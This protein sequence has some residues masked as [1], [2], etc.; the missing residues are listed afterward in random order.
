MV[1][2]RSYLAQPRWP[3]EFYAPS[4]KGR[5]NLASMWTNKVSVEPLQKMMHYWG[6]YITHEQTGFR[7][8]RPYR[9]S[10]YELMSVGAPARIWMNERHAFEAGFGSQSRDLLYKQFNTV[11][12][13]L[14]GTPAGRRRGHDNARLRRNVIRYVLRTRYGINGPGR[15]SL[16]SY[17]EQSLVLHPSDVP[18]RQRYFKN[19]SSLTKGATE[20]TPHVAR[21]LVGW[22]Q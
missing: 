11:Y 6:G 2:R 10:F 15:K 1:R 22:S 19:G 3:D 7:M 12:K 5:T 16:G 21:P 20:P 8:I 9:T 4:T 14:G 18:Q 13:N 17:G